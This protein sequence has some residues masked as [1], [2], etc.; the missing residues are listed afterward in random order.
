[1]RNY[2]LA[3]LCI[4]AWMPAVTAQKA[5][6]YW[7]EELCSCKGKYHTGKY[8]AEELQNTLDYVINAGLISAN[9]TAFQLSQL[10]SIRMDSLEAECT[11]KLN[12]LKTLPFVR[13]PY[14]DSLKVARI[15]EIESQC[16]LERITILAY[17][18][19]DSL[20]KYTEATGLCG[21]YSRPLAAGGEQMLEAWR[22]LIIRQMEKNGDPNRLFNRYQ[23]E[24]RSADSLDYARM[25]LMTFGWW[26]CVNRTIP[27][28]S[29]DYLMYV[30]F[31]K[32]FARKPK[33]K[34]ADPC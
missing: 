19:P 21:Q 14:W 34:C 11:R 26:N 15:Q 1:M 32:L 4:L 7:E 2:L 31:R 3:S 6:F 28:M 9:A 8:T 17:Q 12:Q 13:S 25:E 22:Q 30:A 16:E 10:K 20:V 27:Y 5:T 33:C 18:Y 24:R 29:D 23:A